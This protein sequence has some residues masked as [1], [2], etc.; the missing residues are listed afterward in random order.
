[1]R[2]RNPSLTGDPLHYAPPEPLPS[3]LIAGTT[4]L[5]HLIGWAIGLGM[6]AWLSIFVVPRYE[7]TIADYKLELPYAT[8]LL[9]DSGAL[10]T[11]VEPPEGD[12]TRRL[13]PFPGGTPDPER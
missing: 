12:Y 1:M 7:R 4:F 5:G 13:G 9:A 6:F 11:K 3:P 8:K 10:V 2:P